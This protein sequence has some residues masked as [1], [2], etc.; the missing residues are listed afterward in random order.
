MIAGTHGRQSGATIAVTVAVLVAACLV[1]FS[2]GVAG[3]AGPASS[4][5]SAPAAIQIPVAAE[6]K[7]GMAS[8]KG[9]GA[10]KGKV[11]RFESAECSVVAPFAEKQLPTP[12]VLMDSQCGYLFVPEN[13]A[14]PKGRTIRLAV[15]IVPSVSQPPA[16]DPVVHLAGGPGGSSLIEIESLTAAKVNRNRELILMSQ[17]GTL[18]ADPELSCPELDESF[19]QSL[20][21]PVD[22]T[23]NRDMHLAASRACHLRLAGRGIDFSAYNTV[24]NAA[25][26][27]DLR[28]ALGIDEWNVFGVSYGSYLA[29]TLMYRH[30]KGIRTVTLD[31]VEPLEEANMASTAARNAREAFDNLFAACAAQP[32][33]SARYPDLAG[34]FTRLVNELESTPVTA[35]VPLAANDPPV[36]VVLDGGA[37][38][39]ALIDTSFRTQEF[40]NVPAW[41]DELAHGN[42]ENLAKA[43][44]IPVFIPSG[45][46]A[47]GMTAS[48]LCSGYFAEDSE[49][50]VLAQG[51]LSLPDYPDSV[52]APA[53]HFT[54]ALGDCPVW[55]IRKTRKH[56]RT[57]KRSAIPTLVVSGTF[58]AV[59]PPSTG[60]TAALKLTHS[61]VLAF[62]GVGHAVVQSSRCAQDVFASFLS[63]PGAPDIVCVA[64]LTPEFNTGGTN[65]NARR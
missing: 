34:T 45:V 57:A 58:D 30:P 55:N 36:T 35:S 14:T 56:L 33:C 22:S 29:Q 31:S 43:R 49:S 65:G 28:T 53:L 46:L 12:P 10:A 54:D 40:A 64:E 23:A 42:P 5:S 27:A 21:F 17:R 16:P 15:I 39:N 11:P 19:V 47:Y 13:R 8:I 3:A 7:E 4:V 62:A 2:P 51:R 32:G 52:L 48:M 9:K 41:I 26:F 6:V 61:I 63:D 25:D 24:E 59:T 50:D 1:G 38:V 44:A 37:L 60:E 18:F 20:A